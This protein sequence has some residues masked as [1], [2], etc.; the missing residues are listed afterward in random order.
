MNTDLYNG[1]KRIKGNN[2]AFLVLTFLCIFF[3][4]LWLVLFALN[5]VNIANSMDGN[6]NSTPNFE[7]I[8][9]G[10]QL[11]PFVFGV[12]TLIAL[13][14]C[15]ILNIVFVCTTNTVGSLN[16]NHD[17]AKT[18]TWVG[19]GLTF[20][21]PTIGN[22]ILIVSASQAMHAVASNQETAQPKP[23]ANHSNDI[24]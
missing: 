13:S 3:F 15:M 19:F 16:Q 5:S 2:I 7:D 17:S 23:N 1:Y 24:F 10:V 9:G 6:N 21:L 22:I 18:L 4:V 14:I 11:I 20:C 12:I 8:F